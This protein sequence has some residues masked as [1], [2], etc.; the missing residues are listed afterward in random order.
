MRLMNPHPGPIFLIRS[1]G[2]GLPWSIAITYT[3]ESS[4]YAYCFKE[5]VPVKP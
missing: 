4:L 5:R 3:V 2:S 1:T